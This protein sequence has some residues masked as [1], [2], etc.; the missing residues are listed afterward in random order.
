MKST[1]TF[2]FPSPVAAGLQEAVERLRDKIDEAYADSTDLDRM[3]DFHYLA[4][5]LVDQQMAELAVADP[6]LERG[7]LLDLREQVGRYV[8]RLVE[9]SRRVG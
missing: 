9:Q 4:H 2:Q 7:A 3:A 8:H 5:E 1:D 6:E